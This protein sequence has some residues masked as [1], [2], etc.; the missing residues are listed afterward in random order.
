VTTLDTSQELVC[1]DGIPNLPYQNHSQ[2]TPSNNCHIDW[3]YKSRKRLSLLQAGSATNQLKITSFFNVIDKIT[4][5]V[6]GNQQVQSV[7]QSELE[8]SSILACKPLLAN[9]SPLLKQL[10]C[11][12][13]KNSQKHPHMRRHDEII[14]KFCISL[15]IYCGPMAY[16]FI[17]KNMP[18]AL[19]SLCTVQR[20]IRKDC[21]PVNEGEFRFDQ[22]LSHLKSYKAPNAI[23]IGED[24]TRLISRVDYDSETNKL[25]G[26]VLPVDAKGLPIRDA[27]VATS[28]DFIE[29]SFS[30]SAIAKYA[31]VYMAQC[32]SE[33]IPPF[34][35]G[36]FGTN[37]K[38]KTEDVLKR[39]K[40]IFEECGKRGITVLSFGA[41]GD[42]RELKAMQMSYHL[43][44]KAS[45]VP[46]LCQ[47]YKVPSGWLSWFAVRRSTGMAYV[48]D[49]VHVA[50]KLKS[51]L[52]RVSSILP[53]G[54]YVAGLHHLRLLQKSFGKDQH[55]LR[56]KDINVKDKQN[57]DAVL[58]MTSDS[59]LL[60]MDSIP[61]T[62]GTKMYL[63]M[64]RYIND[65]Y[66]DKNI[67]TAIR[68]KKAWT[69]V[70]FMRYWRQWILLNG[71]Y[72]LKHNFITSNT[73]M[74][75]ELNAHA[76]VL[77]LLKV[78]DS[79]LSGESFLRW[80]LGSQT[81]EK[82]FRSVRSMSSTFSTVINF[83]MLGL[84]RRIHRLHIQLSL[85]S[86]SDETGI[87]YSRV[88]AHKNKDGHHRAVV[89]DAISISD[90]D[91][92]CIVVEA[93]QLAKEM[94]EE[95]KMDNLLKER[96]VW[97]NPPLQVEYTETEIDLDEQDVDHE[98]V[99][100][101]T[102]CLRQI[103]KEVN[104][105]QEDP[106]EIMSGILQ[107]KDTGLIDS[108]ITDNL[109]K[110]HE[111]S[112][113]KA[114]NETI[115]F[116]SKVSN[117]SCKTETKSKHCPYVE[118]KFKGEVL[119][120]HKTTAVWL[121]QEGERVSSDH[122][123]RV[124]NKQ[125]YSTEKQ[126]VTTSDT[127]RVPDCPYVCDSINVGDVCV[128]KCPQK[129]WKVGRVLQ[130]SYYL[131]KNVRSKEYHGTSV[132]F[133]S[134]QPTI[135]VLCSWYE[136]VKPRKFVMATEEVH[137]FIPI[138][139]YLCTL[140]L[141]CFET[142]A[143]S[144]SSANQSVMI[145][146]HSICDLL[147]CTG[148]T[149][150]C[151]SSYENIEPSKVNQQKIGSVWMQFEQYVLTKQDQYR[152][153]NGQWLSDLHIGL[154]QRLVAHKFTN[155][156]GLQHPV[157][158]WKK[159]IQQHSAIQIINISGSHWAV[160]STVGCSKSMVN[161]YDSLYSSISS[162]TIKIIAHL[163]Q[164]ESENFSVSMMNV[165][166]QVGTQDCALFAIAYMTS[167]AYSQDPTTVTYDQDEMRSHILNCF[168][169]KNLL[170]FPSKERRRK[171]SSNVLKTETFKIYCYCR[172]PDDGSKMVCCD[173]CEQ[174]HH[175]SCTDFDESNSNAWF[176]KICT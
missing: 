10:M 4:T 17:H 23:V 66:L 54:Q 101:D 132:S 39:W 147:T 70:F 174:W 114:G 13:E 160:L 176:C 15:F 97:E 104:D 49:M 30:N 67:T 84:L 150:A 19:P 106:H 171:L 22:L 51:R 156:N 125:P 7:V 164:F 59:V 18:E 111:W 162:D 56:E 136:E 112:F 38:F 95:L 46:L 121:F 170:P 113:K 166:K 3:S 155:I 123:F 21:L 50:V 81:C 109:Q 12:A 37:N 25:V 42:P 140:T 94:M 45:P 48:Q 41:D 142:V 167:I 77:F 134:S 14:K 148:F 122:L 6:A 108:E 98:Q 83:S 149:I 20:E 138:A 124:R 63:T 52:L 103:V 105:W 9:L 175:I 115:Q 85:E 92:R 144:K 69:A 44:C 31:F 78:R 145:F 131:E 118:V 93:Q 168:E 79:G 135:G 165:H 74:C 75:I 68:I 89:E 35:L 151:S 117:T 158:Q 24:A 157:Y 36:C 29:K 72:T 71:K 139:S 133:P 60:L 40:Y 43:M 159:V 173:K 61:D 137:L 32:L 65:S 62:K 127:Q 152:I 80:K 129:S 47:E 128:F 96:N 99:L 100:G 143:S 26:F 169:K 163:F 110:L 28:F 119:Y 126:L 11:N 107:L 141:Q 161:L 90:D 64:M 172:L 1:P 53:L 5:L 34:C 86:E 27:F 2:V 16:D 57:Y 55:G 58:R 88:E 33:K 87:R 130:F 146:D 154:A 8:K 102:D 120:I 76:L 91:I 73:Y 116:F 153:S 82:M